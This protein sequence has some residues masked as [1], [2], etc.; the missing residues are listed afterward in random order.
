MDIEPFFNSARFF[1]PFLDIN[2]C[3]LFKNGYFTFQLKNRPRTHFLDL[4]RYLDICL[5]L[6]GI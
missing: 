5:L 6:F 4:Y 1:A 2:N 3:F